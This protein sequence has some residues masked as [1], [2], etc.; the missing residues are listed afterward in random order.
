MNISRMEISKAAGISVGKVKNDVYRGKLDVCDLSSVV[1]YVMVHLMSRGIER[2]SG[3]IDAEA[4]IPME[5]VYERIESQ[6]C[7]G[8]AV[9]AVEAVEDV[10]VVFQPEIRVLDAESIRG[11]QRGVEGIVLRT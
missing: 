6:A 2:I 5:K 9:E 10:D 7:P 1:G 3:I 4:V 11:V 8:E